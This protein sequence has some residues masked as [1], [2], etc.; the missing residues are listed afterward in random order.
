MIGSV[1]EFV[2]PARYF[3]ARGATAVV[4]EYRVFCRSGAGIVAE[5]ADAKSAVRWIRSHASQLHIDP[6]RVA[7]SGGSSGGHLALST[8]LFAE[9]DERGEDRRMSSK[10]NRLVLFYPCVDETTDEEH[11]YGGDAIG[12]HGKDVSPLYHIVPG[13]PPTLLLQGTAD[14]LYTENKRY[15]AEAK[16]KGNQCDFVEFRGAEHGF[17]DPG[18]TTAQWYAKGLREMDQYLTRAGYLPASATA[19]EPNAPSP[20]KGQ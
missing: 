20:S 13:M 7:A 5:I 16:A 17:F 6:T 1:S 18:P 14:D 9:W 12:S 11:S 3:A 15:C 2:S 19:P 8:A 4:V 10:P